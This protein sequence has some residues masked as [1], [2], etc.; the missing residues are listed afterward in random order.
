MKILLKVIIFFC[1]AAF[2][3]Y[4]QN[5]PDSTSGN[6]WNFNAGLYFY[7][8]PDDFY[9]LPI[10]KADADK[11]HLEVRYNYEDRRTVSLWLGYNFIWGKEWELAAAPMIALVV[12]QSNGSAPGLELEL[13]Y[14][15]F[16]LYSEAEYMFNFDDGGS[17]F[18]YNWAELTYSPL[19]WLWFGI[20]G[21]R[22]RVYKT[23]LEIQRG[24]LLGASYE[25][26]QITGYLFNIFSEDTFTTVS[27]TA[28]F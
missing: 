15:S 26:W 28:N 6:K 8:I 2:S 24:L 3:G 17:D 7:F 1:L 11:L 20:V 12:G 10:L 16:E 14:K 19:D 25:T 5:F 27:L 21:Q 13:T 18:L 23:N 9:I 22:T 4:S